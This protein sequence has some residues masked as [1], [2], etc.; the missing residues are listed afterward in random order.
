MK[1]GP[2][3]YI[4]FLLRVWLEATAS[5]KRASRGSFERRLHLQRSKNHFRRFLEVVGA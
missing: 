5:A 2:E 4:Q 3:T 1:H